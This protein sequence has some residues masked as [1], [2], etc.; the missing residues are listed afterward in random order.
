[1][2]SFGL[3]PGSLVRGTLLSRKYGHLVIAETA[4]TLNVRERPAALP[5]SSIR[6]G[7]EMNSNFAQIL[8]HRILTRYNVARGGTE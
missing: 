2:S 5:R 6:Y 3:R 7:C 8:G 4:E 1:M